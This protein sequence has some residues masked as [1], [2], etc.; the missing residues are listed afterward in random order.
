TTLFDAVSDPFFGEREAIKLAYD[1]HGAATPEVDTPH[2][3]TATAQPIA[4]APLAVPDT[5]LA[6]VNA[7]R[8]FDVKAADVVGEV[9]RVDGVS[10]RDVYAFTANAGDLISL[11]VLSRS[12]Y[13]FDRSMDSVLKVYD[14]NGNLVP[15]YG[16]TAVNDDSFQSQDSS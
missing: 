11:E 4:L 3:T 13:P 8:E 10:E 1:D 16:S 15:Y 5:V 7:D 12:L 6:G 2:A 9:R 14:A